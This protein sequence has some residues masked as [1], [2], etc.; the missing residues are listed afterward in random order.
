MLS[1]QK[2]TYFFRIIIIVCVGIFFLEILFLRFVPEFENKTLASSSFI[3]Q[4]VA[5]TKKSSDQRRK[6][7]PEIRKYFRLTY[8]SQFF[9]SLNHLLDVPHTL[10]AVI[11]LVAAF[12]FGRASLTLSYLFDSRR[13]ISFYYVFVVSN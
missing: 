7:A 8:A 12:I 1:Q 4:P 5:P 13:V 2:I 11:F 3:E 6:T 9:Y 10:P